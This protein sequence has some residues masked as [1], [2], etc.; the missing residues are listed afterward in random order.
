[1]L[2]FKTI[3]GHFRYPMMFAQSSRLYSSCPI[4]Y[5]LADLGNDCPRH[6][7]LAA[8]YTEEFPADLLYAFNINISSVSLSQVACCKASTVLKAISARKDNTFLFVSHREPPSYE[9]TLRHPWRW[10]TRGESVC[11]EPKTPWRWRWNSGKEPNA[12]TPEKKPVCCHHSSWNSKTP[13]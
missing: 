11:T 3:S 2:Y 1:M 6:I 10:R 5:S 13:R 7:L 9:I 8:T 12:R 4:I